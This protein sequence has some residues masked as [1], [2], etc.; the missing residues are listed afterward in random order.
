METLMKR[1]KTQPTKVTTLRETRNFCDHQLRWSCL[2]ICP[3]TLLY[4]SWKTAQKP[5]RLL[6]HQLL[7]SVVKS[8]HDSS[9]FPGKGWVCPRER[10]FP[11]A[12]GT[13][14]EE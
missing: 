10:F 3:L 5:T 9:S 11:R 12:E 1:G 6:M 8:L 7:L 13:F 14:S 2:K 4:N